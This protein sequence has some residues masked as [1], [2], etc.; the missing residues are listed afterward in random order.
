MTTRTRPKAHNS[1]SQVSLAMRPRN[2]VAVAAPRVPALR[3]R[4]RLTQA[5]NCSNPSSVWRHA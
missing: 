5:F 4:A 1:L 2:A 3:V